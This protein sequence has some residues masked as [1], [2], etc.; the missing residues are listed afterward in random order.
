MW[1]KNNAT[2]SAPPATVEYSQRAC[3]LVAD[4]IR[5]LQNDT[6]DSETAEQSWLLT[7][8]E[9]LWRHHP[10]Y[11]TLAKDE[12][13]DSRKKFTEED[14]ISKKRKRRADDKDKNLNEDNLKVRMPCCRECGAALQPGYQ[15]TTVRLQSKQK[16][17]RTR[18]SAP[19][20]TGKAKRV[21]KDPVL[22]WKESHA[23][24]L[25]ECRNYL[26]VICGACHSKSLVPGLPDNKNENATGDTSDQDRT[27]LVSSSDKKGKPCLDAQMEKDKK[28]APL[29]ENLDF[30]P[31]ENPGKKGSIQKTSI[32]E[33]RKPKKKKSEKRRKGGSSQ[34]YD[35][36]SSLND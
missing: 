7:I 27:K 35:F 9:M 23:L 6:D 8:S 5:S 14:V 13:G 32:L 4:N 33:Q 11:I 34:L 25:K 28:Q 2:V 22:D 18:Q 19:N 12:V 26:V 20:K 30:V 17:R 31:L 3:Q 15:G 10:G 29:D 16:R 21:K 1:R 24:D 36:L